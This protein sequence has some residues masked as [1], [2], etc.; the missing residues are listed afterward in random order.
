MNDYIKWAKEAGYTGTDEQLKAIG[1]AIENGAVAWSWYESGNDRDDVACMF[2][3]GD[4]E[5]T[6]EAVIAAYAEGA[7][8]EQGIS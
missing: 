4:E 8:N 7:A 3:Y 1:M 2:E 6:E 5:P